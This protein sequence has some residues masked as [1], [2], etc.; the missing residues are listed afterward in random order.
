MGVD[1]NDASR[2]IVGARSVQLGVGWGSG[3]HSAA[4][5]GPHAVEGGRGGARRR[6]A[7]AAAWRV[8]DHRVAR[9]LAANSQAS[10]SAPLIVG[11]LAALRLL[12]DFA[13]YS[14]FGLVLFVGALLWLLST[15]VCRTVW[16]WALDRTKATTVLEYI[17]KRGARRLVVVPHD[18][19]PDALAD[20]R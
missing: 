14:T 8:L 17:G 16:G 12:P 9:A 2:T 20:P 19:L 18:E 7:D 3:E 6:W 10:L 11:F 5:F 13:G 15:M 1:A 4:L